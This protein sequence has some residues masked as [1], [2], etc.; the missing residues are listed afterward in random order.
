MT[1]IFNIDWGN[2]TENLTPWFWRKDNNDNESKLIAYLRSMI[3]PIQTISNTLLAFQQETIDFLKYTGQHT[4]LEEY[5]NDTYDTTLRRIY[6][7]ENDIAA[8]DA[9]NMYLS[10]ETNPS[11]LSFYLSGEVVPVPIA[12]YLSGEGLVDNNFTVNIPVA[13]VFDTTVITAQLRNYVEAS[14]NFNFVTF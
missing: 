7:T 5:L 10:G 2:V 11:P 9:V 3:A 6:I 1:N 13:V 12:F 14:K 8:I 4:S